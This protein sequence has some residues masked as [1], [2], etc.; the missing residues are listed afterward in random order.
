MALY[1][2]IQAYKGTLTSTLTTNLYIVP[3]NSK[4]LIKEIKICNSGAAVSNVTVKAGVAA[5]ELYVFDAMPVQAGETQNHGMAT[6]LDASEVID[7]GDSV[8]GV[9][10]I[11]ISGVLIT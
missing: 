4:L 11:F 10:D 7:G 2:N 5:S 9:V 6:T 8:G 1:T 3:A